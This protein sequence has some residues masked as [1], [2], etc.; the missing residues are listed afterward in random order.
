L[1]YALQTYCNNYVSSTVLSVWSCLQSILAA[2]GSYFF[3]HTPLYVRYLGGIP[4]FV[5]VFLVMW[6][7]KE[8]ELLEL[9]QQKDGESVKTKNLNR[10]QKWFR[11]LLLGDEENEKQLN[12]KKK[13]IINDTTNNEIANEQTTLLSKSSNIVN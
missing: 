12:Q 10:A 2:F 11:K 4:M 8:D 6:K 3:L 13:M 7:S 1:K 9:E 5:G